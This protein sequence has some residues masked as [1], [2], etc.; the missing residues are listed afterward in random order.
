MMGFTTLRLQTTNISGDEQTDK[1]TEK[2]T[3]CFI[4][5]DS[6][7]SLCGYYVYGVLLF[8]ASYEM[9][10]FRVRIFYSWDVLTKE[11]NINMT[12]HVNVRIF[13]SS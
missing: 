12:S 3:M 4:T 5:I 13:P 7:G 6:R 10:N 11:L 1:H 2:S 8:S 9:V